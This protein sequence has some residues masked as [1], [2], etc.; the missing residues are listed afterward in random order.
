[1]EPP[2]DPQTTTTSK[3]ITVTQRGKMKRNNVKV[4]KAPKFS[5]KAYEKSFKVNNKSGRNESNVDHNFGFVFQPIQPSNENK[6]K[7]R[8]SSK[9][10]SMAPAMLS[11][12]ISR[13]GAYKN[14]ETKRV[15]KKKERPSISKGK[16]KISINNKESKE[17]PRFGHMRKASID[18]HQRSNNEPKSDFE[19]LLD[20]KVQEN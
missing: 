1:M 14:E 3:N 11:F 15:D 13:E 19:R 2:R 8:L 5:T 12:P 10:N 18:M 6:Q 4:L 16:L 17:V 20:E 9:R 7:V